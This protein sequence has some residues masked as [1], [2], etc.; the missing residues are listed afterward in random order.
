MRVKNS[1]RF[2]LGIL[3][4]HKYF[5]ESFDKR[6]YMMSKLTEHNSVA[7]LGEGDISSNKRINILMY[8]KQCVTLNYCD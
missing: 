7:V 8:C 3:I 4:V 6:D 2:I 5:R 1:S